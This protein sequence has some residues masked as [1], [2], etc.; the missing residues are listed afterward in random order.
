MGE[1]LYRIIEEYRA[2]YIHVIAFEV[3]ELGRSR[4]PPGQKWGFLVGIRTTPEPDDGLVYGPAQDHSD[5]Y[6]RAAAEQAAL[7]HGRTAIDEFWALR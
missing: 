1:K 6:T 3:E 7:D 2:M 5:Y 4:E